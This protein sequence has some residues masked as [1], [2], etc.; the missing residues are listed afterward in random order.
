MTSAMLVAEK[1]DGLDSFTHPLGSIECPNRCTSIDHVGVTT[2]LVD[3]KLHR[4]VLDEVIAKG[5]D[6]T[7]KFIDVALKSN[8]G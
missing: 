6:H 5:S 7:P 3:V 2:D 4:S 8:E 1:G